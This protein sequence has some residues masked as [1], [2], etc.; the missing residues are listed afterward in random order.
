MHLPPLR[1]HL[2]ENH[3]RA[4]LRSYEIYYNRH[5]N[6]QGMENQLLV[7]QLLP[8]EGGIRCQK[9]VAWLLNY[10]YRQAA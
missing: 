3:L 7:P 1:P 9:Q 8:V 10:Y 4:A 5:R 6:H 2:G